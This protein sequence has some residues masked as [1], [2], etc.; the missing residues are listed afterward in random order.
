LGPWKTVYY[1]QFLDSV[2][3]FTYQFPQKWMA[4]VS[5]NTQNFY[6]AFSGYPAYDHLSII[7]ATFT[8]APS[9]T[10]TPPLSAT[11]C[12]QLQRRHGSKPR[13]KPTHTPTAS[14]TATP[15]LFEHPRLAGSLHLLS[16]GR[17]CH[18]RRN[19][20]MVLDQHLHSCL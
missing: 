2:W 10:A 11:R 18:N 14:P 19:E 1:G 5:G 8:L 13:A 4:P 16:D 17:C 6:M 15:T 7:Q 9:P 3:K 20:D 12:S